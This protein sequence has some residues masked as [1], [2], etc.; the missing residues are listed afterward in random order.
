MS[1]SSFPSSE[2]AEPLVLLATAWPEP[3][4]AQRLRQLA[5]QLSEVSPDALPA[6]VLKRKPRIVICDLETPLEIAPDDAP[7]EMIWIT[8]PIELDSVV[9]R[10]RSL[11]ALERS[12]AATAA[13]AEAEA[14][15]LGFDPEAWSKA[16]RQIPQAR[17]SVEIGELLDRAERRVTEALPAEPAAPRLTPEQELAAVLPPEVLEALDEPLGLEEDDDDLDQ[18]PAPGT[19]SGSARPGNPFGTDAG[20]QH[21]GTAPGTTS[22]TGPGSHAGEGPE[23]LAATRASI[24]PPETVAVMPREDDT[25]TSNRPP[26]PD[27]DRAA[28]TRFPTRP[29][30]PRSTTDSSPPGQDAML[31]GTVIPAA[32]RV[33]SSS[34]AEH[35]RSGASPLRATLQPRSAPPESGSRA[36]A[37]TLNELAGGIAA[38]QPVRLS[39][40]PMIAPSVPPAKPKSS[41][42]NGH[43]LEIPASLGRGDGVRALARAVRERYTGALAFETEGGMR[44]VVFKE[45]DFVTAASGI[46]GESLVAFLTQRGDLSPDAARLTRRLPQFG[47]HAGAALIAHGYLRQDELWT[48]LR[49]HAEWLVGHVVRVESGSAS[50]ERQVPGRL[51]AEPAVFGGATGAE[52]LVEVVRR[53]VPAAEAVER[54]GGA[55]TK[56]LQGRKQQLL[57]E[58]A[59]PEREGEIVSSAFGLSVREVC[60]QAGSE[61]FASVIYALTELSVL[62][63]QPALK[64]ARPRDSEPSDVLDVIDERAL[65]SRIAARK[66]LV[67]EGDYF[68]LL[69]VPRSATG[70]DIRRAYVGLRRE[71]EP[72]RILTAQTVDLR[73]DVDEIVEV[74]EEA[75]EVLSDEPRRERYRRALEAVP[76]SG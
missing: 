44:R 41:P 28:S 13:A 2:T 67:D 37:G 50:V 25:G 68:A 73:D 51:E 19:R 63:A 8:R 1:E 53:E 56:L 71:F 48:V 40:M 34:R 65:R 43:A 9:G 55:S 38:P 59:L 15:A 11:L 64:S 27:A 47:R 12:P 66:A 62:E 17:L 39:P 76:R 4:L 14:A 74:L 57:T 26:D 60:R 54:L 20:V 61:E 45:G 75:F 21:R 18:G 33:P 52:I 23:A 36:D 69:G 72:S 32:P 70:Y 42:S 24:P 3:E 35:E 10:A 49:A 16:A 29:P 46:D 5:V 30:P 58:C 31:G 7:P 22:G 6:Q